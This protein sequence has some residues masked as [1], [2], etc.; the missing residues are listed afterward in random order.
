MHRPPAFDGYEDL[1]RRPLAERDPY[2]FNRVT[3]L[4]ER[5]DHAAPFA[6]LVRQLTGKRVT[7]EQ[8]RKHWAGLIALKQEMESRLGRVISVQTAAVE[9]FSMLER[10][11]DQLEPASP[12]TENAG[13][14]LAEERERCVKR[15]KNEMMRARRYHHA[16]SSILLEVVPR[17]GVQGKDGDAATDTAL[18]IVQ[19]TI[20]GVDML[21]RHDE[22]RFII[23]L[24]N[25]NKRE[26]M[27]LAE[28]VH[29][30]IAERTSG[31]LD[32]TLS[33]GQC[34]RDETVQGFLTLL[35]SALEGGKR[36]KAGAVYSAG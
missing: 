5:G 2:S 14:P 35:E 3:S 7:A 36:V 16:L 12:A 18:K 21:F 15:L 26:A 34:E 22:Q 11:G 24:P 4:L 19:L 8:G 1:I 13:N 28:R 32:V 9:Y 6:L 29:D 31:Q 20:R 17:S 23:L 25:T 27:E 33:A 30:N 10:A